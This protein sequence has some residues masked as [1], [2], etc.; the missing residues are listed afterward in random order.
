MTDIHSRLLAELKQDGPY[1]ASGFSVFHENKVVKSFA[2]FADAK[3]AA[4][5]LNA[6]HRLASILRMI[7]ED[8]G[9]RKLVAR[10][11]CAASGLDVEHEARAALL[12]L[13]SILPEEK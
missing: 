8:E 1:Y 4:V 11:I 2:L 10:D 3:N 12:T 5:G 6:S 9:M 13:L 7:A